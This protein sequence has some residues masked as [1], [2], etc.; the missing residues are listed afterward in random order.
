VVV[1][2]KIVLVA[3]Q[4]PQEID[5]HPV[6]MAVIFNYVKVI[7]DS[8]QKP[9]GVGRGRND[10]PD[11]QANANQSRQEPSPDLLFSRAQSDQGGSQF[12]Q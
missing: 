4:G 12:T 10:R 7:L 9:W 3:V 5:L 2:C 1:I 6:R 8:F 11:R